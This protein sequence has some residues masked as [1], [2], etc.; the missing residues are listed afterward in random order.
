M[1]HVHSKTRSR[2]ADKQ[3]PLNVKEAAALENPGA[4]NGHGCGGT[5]KLSNDNSVGPAEKAAKMRAREGARAANCGRDPTTLVT[6]TGT[7]V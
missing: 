3:R 4:A 1:L 5:S 6:L 7:P 2:Q